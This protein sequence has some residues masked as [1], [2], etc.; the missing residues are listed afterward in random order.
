M[1]RECGLYHVR[2]QMGTP[3][4]HIA[5]I[6]GGMLAAYAALAF[7]ALFLGERF[8]GVGERKDLAARLRRLHILALAAFIVG[9]GLAWMAFETDHPSKDRHLLLP[10]IFVAVVYSYPVILLVQA[11][12][13]GFMW[14]IVRALLRR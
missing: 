10:I 5:L 11:R 9:A 3:H 4:W 6:I 1:R 7:L 13:I 2:P 14:Q 8:S 12:A